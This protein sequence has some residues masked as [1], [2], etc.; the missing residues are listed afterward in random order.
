M[1]AVFVDFDGTIT[2][3]DTLDVLMQ[4]HDEGALAWSALEAD[5]AAGRVTLRET[6]ERQA[7]HVALTLD[8][9]DAILA[10]TVH[11]DPTFAPFIDRCERAGHALV[12]VSSGIASLIR[13]AFAR[14]GV[15]EIALVANDVHPHADGW[16]M[17]FASESE[18]GTDKA[19]L[20]R[21]ARDA[22]QRTV[23]IGDGW[24][25]VAAAREADVRF[26][27]RDRNLQRSLER[28]GLAFTPF[29]RFADIEPEAFAP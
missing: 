26:A 9:A 22:G 6:L 10:R 15:G 19:A 12:V 20:V 11:F 2:N 29:A 7:A 14:N 5:L 17:R 18:N 16:R 24:S 21:R 25:D 23:F 13:R 4:Q 3:L 27:K 28:E 8:E 1:A